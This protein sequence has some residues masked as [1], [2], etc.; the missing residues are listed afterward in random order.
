MISITVLGLLFIAS[1]AVG[2]HKAAPGAHV[3]FIGTT[4]GYA[5]IGGALLG[6]ALHS[7]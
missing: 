1:A 5:A 6:M 2:A 3:V 4:V 7:Y